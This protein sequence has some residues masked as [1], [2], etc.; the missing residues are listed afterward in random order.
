MSVVVNR[1]GIFLR[2]AATFEGDLGTRDVLD[3]RLRTDGCGS[4]G[5]ERIEIIR[6]NDLQTWSRYQRLINE[7]D[8]A[9]GAD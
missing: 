1:G 3:V 5:G 9:G 2:N 6:G 4:V 8:S 7:D